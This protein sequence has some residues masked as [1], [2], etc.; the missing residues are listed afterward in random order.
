M[1]TINEEYT[2][3]SFEDKSKGNVRVNC[4]DAPNKAF[5]QFRK[6]MVGAIKYKRTTKI[7]QRNGY[8]SKQKLKNKISATNIIVPGKPKNIRRFTNAIINSLGQI[9]LIPLISVINRVLKRR[10]IASTRRKELV[11][12]SA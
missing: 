4:T 3:N 2:N 11:E 8:R 10:P 6:K 1:S 7:K 12:R 9:K 5:I